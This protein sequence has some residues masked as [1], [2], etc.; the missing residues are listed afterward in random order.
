MS[1]RD[2]IRQYAEKYA[3]YTAENLSRLVRTKSYSSKEEDVC[4]LI[5]KLCEEAGFDEVRICTLNMISLSST[6]TALSETMGRA[7]SL[8]VFVC[9]AT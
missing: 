5:V 7:L 2:E 4:R 1:I 8:S 9:D 6:V 3:S